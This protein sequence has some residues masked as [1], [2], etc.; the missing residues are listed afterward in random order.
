MSVEALRCAFPFSTTSSPRLSARPW[1]E[2][3]HSTYV[4]YSR[5]NFVASSRPWNLA[6]MVTFAFLPSIFA[7]PDAPRI[8]SVAWNATLTPLPWRKCI[9]LRVRD[10]LVDA[11][12]LA[13]TAA[14]C[15]VMK[16]ELNSRVAQ[17]KRCF[18]WSPVGRRCKGSCTAYDLRLQPEKEGQLVLLLW[19]HGERR[20]QAASLNPI[21]WR[22]VGWRHPQEMRW[23]FC[24]RGDP[25]GSP[26][27]SDQQRKKART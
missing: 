20:P 19:L 9:A 4:K 16:L 25:E 10:T 12:P 11:G 15:A 2:T 24:K 8:C 17:T 6:S 7:S 22:R 14:D 13:A 27:W 26:S 21:G 1:G 3:A 18:T 5:P 23:S